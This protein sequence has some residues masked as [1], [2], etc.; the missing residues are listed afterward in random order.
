VGHSADV[1]GLLLV[2]ACNRPLQCTVNSG[3]NEAAESANGDHREWHTQAEVP[4]FV[5]SPHAL[6]SPTVVSHEQS[7]LGSGRPLCVIAGGI[8]VT[9]T[10]TQTVFRIHMRLSDAWDAGARGGPVVLRGRRGSGKLTC[11]LLA[12]STSDSAFHFVDV[13]KYVVGTEGDRGSHSHSTPVSGGVP[14]A[15]SS[16]SSSSS[17]AAAAA[18][19]A[20]G[21]TDKDFA[22]ELH[23]ILHAVQ[24]RY[25]TRASAALSSIPVDA[26]ALR[27]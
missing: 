8:V 15:A 3:G 2:G 4:A 25:V 19:S 26:V 1:R 18:A 14:V 9:P 17:A 24:T 10:I 5:T 12:C 11:L 22:A 7:T 23:H 16:S 21:Y 13:S 20:Q 6:D 27:R